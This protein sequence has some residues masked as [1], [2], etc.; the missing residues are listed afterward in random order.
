MQEKYIQQFNKF[1]A[2]TNDFKKLP[3]YKKEAI[4]G[5]I[6]E[7]L[8]AIKCFNS[9]IFVNKIVEMLLKY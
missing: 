9:P 1:K 3:K 6:L 7:K 4:L 5:E 8:V 2:K